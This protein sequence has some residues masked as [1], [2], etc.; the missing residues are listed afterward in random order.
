MSYPNCSG[1]FLNTLTTCPG[2][3]VYIYTYITVWYSYLDVINLGNKNVSGNDYVTMAWGVRFPMAAGF[4][5]GASYE[6]PLSN[7]EDIT[8]QR[9]TLN[10]TW[11]F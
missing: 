10:V 2:G 11:E 3:F 9:V 7:R 1:I 4:D 5:I 8:E 6:R